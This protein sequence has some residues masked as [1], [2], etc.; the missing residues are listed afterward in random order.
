MW[1]FVLDGLGVQFYFGGTSLLIV[2]GV[3]MDTVQQLEAQ[4]VMRNYEGFVRKGTGAQSSRL[5]R[6][7]PAVTM[8]INRAFIFLGPPG[9]GKGTQAK[10]IAKHCGVPHLSTGDMMRDAVS[11]GTDLGK[12]VGPIMERGELVSD[13]L[14]MKMVEE[15]LAQP[16]CA[17]RMP[18]RRVSADPAA[19]RGAGSDFAKRGIRQ[20]GRGGFKRWRRKAA[21]AP[22][23]PPDVQRGRRDLQYLRRAAESGRDLR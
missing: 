21:A 1:R 17:A 5:I 15:R 6:V 11:R 12:I 14:V 20:A 4:L 22:H 10:R 23:G 7:G 8:A 16:D 9:A 13:D 2:V 18:L 3:A 19:G